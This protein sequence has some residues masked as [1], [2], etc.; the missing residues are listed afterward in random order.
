MRTFVTIARNPAMIA[1]VSAL[2]LAGCASKKAVPNTAAD[3]GLNAN[4]A[5]PGSTQDFTVNV[6]DRI[7]FDTD[8][9]AV[10]ADAQATLQ[11]QAQWLSRYG[12]Y[13][14]TIEDDVF[15]GPN[16]YVTDQNHGFDDP[17]LPI[18][19]QS[20]GE[21]PV[22]I[23]EGSWLGANVVVLPGVTIGKH[24]AVGAGSVVTKDLPDHCVAV[25]SPARVIKQQ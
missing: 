9:S 7:F 15:F 25:G 3:L 4:N 17:N 14:I 1:L 16:V 18:G 20:V 21:E 6:G 24:V 19:R 2:A 12:N 11:R 8:S 10:R 13:S 5:A 22:R 23:G